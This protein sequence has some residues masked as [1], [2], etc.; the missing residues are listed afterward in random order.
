MILATIERASIGEGACL[1]AL[2][3]FSR[4]EE[5]VPTVVDVEDTPFGQYWNSGEF[6][7]LPG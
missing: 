4:F 5:L 6:R 3:D 7:R 2:P 1:Y